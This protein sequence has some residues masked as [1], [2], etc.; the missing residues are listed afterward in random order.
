[1]VNCGDADVTNSDK[2]P[3]MERKNNAICLLNLVIKSEEEKEPTYVLRNAR[4]TPMLMKPLSPWRENHNRTL[5][6][7]RLHST[8]NTQI[9]IDK[10]GE[11]EMN[12][13]G[14]SRMNAEES[15]RK[16]YWSW[17]HHGPIALPQAARSACRDQSQVTK[18]SRLGVRG[19]S[20]RGGWLKAEKEA[21]M[22]L[23][24]RGRHLEID[25]PRV[26]RRVQRVQIP[27]DAWVR[28]GR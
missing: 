28:V 26:A 25:A 8:A 22:S 11:G 2:N 23:Q 4:Q 15:G 12:R 21:C 13:G 6:Q 3:R 27:Q 16:V 7:M 19:V 9:E 24:T 5:T 20:W 1:M 18:V 10:K 14:R 17:Q